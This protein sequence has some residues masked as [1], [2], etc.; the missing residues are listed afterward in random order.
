MMKEMNEERFSEKPYSK[1]SNLPN[2]K[3]K[4]RRDENLQDKRN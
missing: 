4:G 1:T 2:R 3:E